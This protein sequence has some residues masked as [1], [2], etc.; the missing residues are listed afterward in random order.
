MSHA[1]I[2]FTLHLRSR[3]RIVCHQWRLPHSV[4]LEP[5]SVL[6]LVFGR[7]DGPDQRVD[8]SEGLPLPPNWLLPAKLNCD[9]RAKGGH[10]A[11]S[12]LAGF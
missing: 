10:L 1:R 4:R 6:L 5:G 8:V 11:L 2:R 12:C 9:T 7:D 3:A